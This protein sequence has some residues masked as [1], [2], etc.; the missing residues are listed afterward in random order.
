[1]RLINTK[2]LELH[3]F[4]NDNVPPYAIL[5]HT[6]GTEEV[7]FQDWQNHQV[8]VSKQGYL[9]IKNACQERADV[10]TSSGQPLVYSRLDTPGTDSATAYGVLCG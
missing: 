9:K 1:M 8:A 5:S 4:F 2:T 6:W 10:F 7:T 3:E